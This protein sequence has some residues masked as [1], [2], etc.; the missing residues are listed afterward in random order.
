MT[1]LS[2]NQKTSQKNIR[3]MR[4]TNKMSIDKKV[5]DWGN[6]DNH[7]VSFFDL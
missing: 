2:P 3:L 5:S 7:G 1:N 6:C 4:V